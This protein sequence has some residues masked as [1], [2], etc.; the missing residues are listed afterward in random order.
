MSSFE[1]QAISRSSRATLSVLYDRY[2][3]ESHHELTPESFAIV[4]NRFAIPPG[5]AV[6]ETA[7]LN[8]GA[9]PGLEEHNPMRQTARS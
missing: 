6:T 1:N 9:D 3:P 7:G 2:F 4:V 8:Q 5:T